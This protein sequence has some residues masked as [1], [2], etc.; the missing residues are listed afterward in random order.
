MAMHLVLIKKTSHILSIWSFQKVRIHRKFTQDSW[1]LAFKECECHVT[2]DSEY[3]YLICLAT[4]T[5]HEKQGIWEDLIKQSLYRRYSIW[6]AINSAK[7]CQH[8]YTNCNLFTHPLHKL[9]DQRELKINYIKVLQIDY[10]YNM[11]MIILGFKK[12]VHLQ[13]TVDGTDLLG[14]Q[15]NLWFWRRTSVIQLFYIMLRDHLDLEWLCSA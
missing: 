9:P 12:R 7:I 1:A 13:K 3:N 8:K 11:Q 14:S 4:K 15:V 5:S 2:T 6:S 10:L